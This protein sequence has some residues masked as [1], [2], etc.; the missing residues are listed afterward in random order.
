MLEDKRARLV[1]SFI[2]ACALWFY[3]VGQL[4]PVTKKT[5]RGIS[6]TLA[7]EQS[8][9]DSGLAVLSTSDDSLRVTV[10]GKRNAVSRLSKADIVATV[11]LT[12]A[13][14]GANKLPIDLK[15][16][17]NIEIDNQSLNEITVNVEERVTEKRN[18]KVKYNGECPEGMEPTTVKT[19]PETVEISGASS[20]VGQVV[21]V[22]AEIDIEDMPEELSSTISQLTAIDSGGNSV[23]QLSMSDTQCKVTSIIYPTKTVK[24]VV[25]VKDDPNDDYAKTT[26]CQD[27]ITIKGPADDLK[28]IK[29]VKTEPIDVSG[30]E[31]DREIQVIPVLPDG[32]YV[33]EKDKNIKMAVTVSKKDQ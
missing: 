13:A 15:I 10:S 27:Q 12:N 9:S 31:E 29:K 16:P 17:E 8:L 22:K 2:L 24:L 7:N 28:D 23:D 20:I 19:D 30:I 33:A 18:V 32:I 3:V 11:D 25:E 21:N 1:I 5:Y 6:I 4:D 26:K 14:E